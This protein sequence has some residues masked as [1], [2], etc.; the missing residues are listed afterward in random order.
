MGFRFRKSI[1]VGK[2][3]RINLSKSGIGYSFGGKGFR[4]TKM[5]NG[6]TRNTFSIPGTGISYVDEKGKSKSKST[7]NNSKTNYDDYNYTNGEFNND[8]KE[9]IMKKRLKGIGK[10]IGAFILFVISFA[11]F[12]ALLILGGLALIIYH[13][14]HRQ[15]FSE[16]SFIKKAGTIVL[17]LFLILF[18][19]AS[20]SVDNAEKP[21][22]ELADNSD[23]NIQSFAAVPVP[24][25]T[26]DET[27][28]K[29]QPE[30]QPT[31]EEPAIQEQ[32]IKEPISE[33][34]T[35]Q[36]LIEEQVSEEPT[37]HEIPTEEPATEELQ[38][39]PAVIVPIIST[40]ETTKEVEPP[41]TVTPTAEQISVYLTNTGA[42]YH[43]SNCRFLDESRYETTLE[44]AISQ[45]YVA[46]KVCKPPK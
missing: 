2:G 7:Y 46:C 18:G 4:K 41:A 15:A 35:Q 5:S 22:N 39:P 25:N 38:L 11:Y 32:P 26:V 24:I 19:S 36:E 30:E 34:V 21:S 40:E 23:S 29:T 43:K 33:E 37:P 10:S 27:P 17:V 20:M 3:F 16:K 9:S 1:N 12:P 44:D 28:I 31:I 13:A 42:K 8:N 14:T 6:R 45:G